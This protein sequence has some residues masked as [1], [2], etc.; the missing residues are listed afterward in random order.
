[1][2][3]KR[4]FLVRKADGEYELTDIEPDEISFVDRPANK[5]KF[6]VVKRDGDNTGGTA[7]AL[8][9]TKDEKETLAKAML[10][11]KDRTEHLDKAIA[12]AEET[13]DVEKSDRSGV[14]TLLAALIESL[15]PL[16]KKAADPEAPPAQPAQV[17]CKA[18]Q[19][20]GEMPEDGNCPR[21]GKALKGE[22]AKEDTAKAMYDE[23]KAELAKVT[24]EIA[25]LRT[26]PVA[27]PLKVTPP[28]VPADD[29]VQKA[30]DAMEKRMEKIE[31]ALPTVVG[32]S[33]LQDEGNTKGKKK[34]PADLAAEV[35]REKAAKA[36]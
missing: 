24:E 3:S 1:M 14:D 21:C 30:L 19:W 7:M 25:K 29:K 2:N 22:A 4:T 8:K 13:E 33:Q 17:Q 27:D 18:C 26:P 31:K 5:R 20:K 16:Q 6:V 10:I 32:S 9:L 11:I 23:M 12:D 34:W 28:V 36:K 15:A 35:A